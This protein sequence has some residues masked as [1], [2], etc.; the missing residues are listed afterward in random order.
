[1]ALSVPAMAAPAQTEEPCAVA[2][3]HGAMRWPVERLNMPSRC[4]I[5]PVVN[6]YTTSGSV[7][8]VQTPVPQEVFEHLIDHPVLLAALVE[9]MKLGNYTFIIKGERRFWV[10]DGEGTQGM[11]TLLHRDDRVR[12]YHLD[13][14]HEGP[15]LPAVR[16]SAVIFMRLLP[17]SDREGQPAVE[18]H[19]IVYTKLKDSVLS[20]VVRMLQ[21]LVG[22]AVTRKLSKGF[23]VAN[24][25][26]TLIAQDPRRLADEAGHLDGQNSG[27][28]KAFQALVQTLKVPSPSPLSNRTTP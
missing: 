24:K 9:R 16:A 19:L 27:D 22:E 10:D 23:D 15:V 3:E 17:V 21:P 25:L 11:L 7:G 26:G 6:S 20:A 28:I 2:A 5:G 4:L 8:P 14:T 18:S 13:G 12:V 1:M